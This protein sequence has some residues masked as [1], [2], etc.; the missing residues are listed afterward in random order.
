MHRPL[1]GLNQLTETDLRRMLADYDA[2]LA[3]SSAAVAANA[4]LRSRAEFLADAAIIRRMTACC[5]YALQEH[6]ETI[7]TLLSEAVDCYM[8]MFSL[9]NLWQEADLRAQ[10]KPIDVSF[11]SAERMYAAVIDSLILGRKKVLERVATTDHAIYSNVHPPVIGA[12]HATIGGLV[13]YAAGD[14]ASAKRRIG[15]LLTRPDWQGNLTTVVERQRPL[16][17]GVLAVCGNDGAGA[18]AALERLLA[19]HRR[20]AQEGSGARHPATLLCAEGLA[21]AAMSRRAGLP[22][23]VAS[24]Y[25]PLELIPAEET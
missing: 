2:R 15:R 3:R 20:H 22:V 16:L 18:A 9:R 10:K 13:A 11:F 7:P 17:E 25:L 24:P 21:L 4:T 1:E 5:R 14:I 6:L 23:T 12:Y 8:T 19:V